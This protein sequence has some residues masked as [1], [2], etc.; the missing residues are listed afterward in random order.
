MDQR[1]MFVPILAYHEIAAPPDTSS[2]LAV[3]PGAFAAQVEHLAAS[4]FTTITASALAAAMSGTGPGLPE[5]P[6][7]LTF[8][9]GFADFHTS[10]LPLLQRFGCTAT[11]FVTT[12][13]IEDVGPHAAGPRPGRMLS[14]AQVAEAGDGGTEIGSHSHRHPEL[15]QLASSTLREELRTSKGLLEDRLGRAVPGMAYPFGYSSPRVRQA[16]GDAGHQYACAVG[17]AIARPGQ[18]LFALPRLT[19]RRSTGLRAFGG[20][21]RGRAIPV[22]YGKD[23]ALTWGWAKVR[24]SR[25]FLGG[26]PGRA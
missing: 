3:S 5:R 21:V 11:V 20:V 4:G 12:G 23:R 13:W 7:V 22:T 2:R 8:D 16:V 25:A 10:A 6:V 9:D 15:D 18:D 1:A 14:W 19:I 17:N 24:R 26:V